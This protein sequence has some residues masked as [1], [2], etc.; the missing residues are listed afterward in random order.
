[1]YLI[2]TNYYKMI[3]ELHTGTRS[4]K[5]GQDLA[6]ADELRKRWSTTAPDLVLTGGARGADTIVEDIAKELGIPTE[7]HRP[8][9]NE[10]GVR[11][12]LHR[13]TTLVQRAKELGAVV[14]AWK[15]NGPSAGTDDTLRKARN[16]DLSTETWNGE[17]WDCHHSNQLTLLF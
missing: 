7:T 15:P 1:M 11:A 4:L 6:I 14:V 10:Y 13:N 8:N 9:Y 5:P 17:S 3:A 2:L 16:A 12:P